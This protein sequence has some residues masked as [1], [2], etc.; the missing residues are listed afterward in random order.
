M[1]T[2]SNTGRRQ[3]P[4]AAEAL[5]YAGGALV[6]VGAGLVVARTWESLGAGGRVGVLAT[7][8]A[9]AAVAAWR[10]PG[11]ADRFGPPERLEAT[12]WLVSTIALALA[13][14]VGVHDVL[15]FTSPQAVL[16]GGAAVGFVV[17]AAVWRGQTRPLQQATTWIAA[18]IGAGALGGHL[19][20]PGGSGSAAAAVGLVALYAGLTRRT[21]PSVVAVWCGGVILLVSCQM[22][23]GQWQ[24]FGL[25]TSVAVG[26][27]LVGAAVVPG[28][29]V[30]RRHV[31]ACAVP[32]GV[33]LITSLPGAIGYHAERAALLTGMVVW[34]AAVSLMWLALPPRRLRTPIP[35]WV[36]AAVLYVVGPAVATADHETPALIAGLVAAVAA[37]G[38]GVAIA[39][40]PPT[41]IGALSLLVFVPWTVTRLV[42]GALAAPLSIVVAGLVIVS[43]ALWLMR[44]R[45]ITR[46]DSAA[47]RPSSHVPGAAG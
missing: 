44:H 21:K 26:A 40:V 22:I 39:S 1:D 34:L 46:A 38:A 6:L 30:D 47:S 19:F 41:L 43:V 9:V 17:S 4:V 23:A 24:S 8:G 5:G 7:A 15:D 35:V 31:V 36:L 14:G 3:W 10:T 33:L 12:L 18:A 11:R 37:V 28:P 27:A 25:L 45:Q 32:G 42:P 2:L 29:V 16:S 20:A 13:G